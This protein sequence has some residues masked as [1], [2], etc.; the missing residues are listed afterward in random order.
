MYCHLHPQIRAYEANPKPVGLAFGGTIGNERIFLDEDFSRVL[1]RHHA[2]DKT[3]QHGSL[4]PNQVK[5]RFT[6]LCTI[7]PYL[8]SYIQVLRTVCC[9]FSAEDI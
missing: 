7:P 9:C 1:V 6:G 5:F 8:Q 2:V 4:I 3:Y